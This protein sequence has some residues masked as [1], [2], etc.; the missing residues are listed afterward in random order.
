MLYR[1][2]SFAA[3]KQNPAFTQQLTLPYINVL[4]YI[5]EREIMLRFGT[6]LSVCFLAAV[7]L[8]MSPQGVAA[9]SLRT[10][11]E[12]RSSPSI[13][14]CLQAASGSE[15]C[16]DSFD[17]ACVWCAEPVYGLCVTSSV[18][19]KLGNLPFFKCDNDTRSIKTNDASM[20]TELG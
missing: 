1:D 18:A 9:S 17:G 16:H 5:P 20:P 10:N 6:S 15:E 12:L 14:D 19:S 13:Y 3:S 11:P 2:R 8:L 4:D 7:V